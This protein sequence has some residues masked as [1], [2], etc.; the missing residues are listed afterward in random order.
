MGAV[1]NTVYNN[2]LTTYT[3]KSQTRYDSHKKSELR[4]IYNSIVKLNKDSPWYLPTTGRDVQ[5]YAVD[6]KENARQLYN[7]IAELGGLEDRG[8]LN[9]K[10]AYSTN[11]EVASA[12]F[13]GGA[14]TE[15]EMPEFT[16]EVQTLASPQENMGLYLPA[17]NV[18]LAPDTYSFDIAINDMN[19]EF[20]FS[21]GEGESNRAVQERL[22]RLI[23][24]SDIGIKA[25]VTESD[26]RTS[27]RME[28]EAS[29]LGFGKTA[30]FAI[31]DDHTSKTSGA[32]A[33][34][35][36]D[37]VSH[38]ASNASFCINGEER[39]ATSN[40]FTVSKLFEV[41]LKGISPE[42]R[43]VQIGLKTDI[44]SITDNVTHLVQGYNGFIQ[45]AAAY[46]ESQSKSKHL[47]AEMSGITSLYNDSLS[48]MGLQLKEDGQLEVNSDKLRQTAAEAED[49]MGTFGYMRDLSARLLRKSNQISLNPMNYVDKTIVAYKNPHRSF[50]SPYITSAYSGMLFNGYC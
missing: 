5:Q 28:S 25:S 29:G 23:N 34:F 42:D 3:P 39:S 8:L 16:L 1:L 21:I 50:V 20:Q 13:I 24:N 41:Q 26:S 40:H 48:G 6:L 15:E 10:S 11:E 35:G 9:K 7:V 14:V 30:L 45:A 49:I 47:I 32:V 4:S 38:E 2:Y 33:Y 22:A 31:T 18:S 17:G 12:V 46:T 44:E 19:Y 43:P 36:L 27:L 37:Y